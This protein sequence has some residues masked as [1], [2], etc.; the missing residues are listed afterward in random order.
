[1]SHNS[2]KTHFVLY[3][4]SDAVPVFAHKRLENPTI[5]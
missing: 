3:F 2:G 4:S 5:G 1:M